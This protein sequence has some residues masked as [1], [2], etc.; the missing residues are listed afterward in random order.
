[1][2]EL[3]YFSCQSLRDGRELTIFLESYTNETIRKGKMYHNNT[4]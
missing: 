1:M 2:Y 3:S 4:L